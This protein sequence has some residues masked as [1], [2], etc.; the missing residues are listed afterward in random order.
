LI[1]YICLIT[2][3]MDSHTKT[4][5][6]FAFAAQ[7][8]QNFLDECSDMI[9]QEQPTKS[10]QWVSSNL[11]GSLTPEEESKLLDEL[12]IKYAPLSSIVQ[13]NLLNKNKNKILH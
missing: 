2:N 7:Q 9:H 6:Q 3:Q 13:R 10:F 8:W 4:H 12:F 1:N 5:M 11:K